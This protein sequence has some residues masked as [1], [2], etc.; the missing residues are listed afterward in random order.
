MGN[1]RPTMGNYLLMLGGQVGA[2][3]LFLWLVE[4]RGNPEAFANRRAVRA[5]RLWAM[6]S[7]TIWS[8]EIFELLPRALFGAVHNAISP[9]RIDALSHGFVGPGQEPMAVLIAVWVMVAFHVL[10]VVWSRF[11]FKYTFEWFVIRIA[12]LGSGRLS[13]RLDVEHMMNHVQWARFG[14]GTVAASQPRDS[15]TRLPI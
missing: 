6:A 8:L 12:S 7:L 10:V 15:D 3:L 5:L 4:F 14:E 1:N 13:R 11:D 2:M 9:Q